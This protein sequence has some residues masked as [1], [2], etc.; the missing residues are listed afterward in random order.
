MSATLQNGIRL[1]LFL[2]VLMSI[3]V[4]VARVYASSSVHKASGLLET[5]LYLYALVIFCSLLPYKHTWIMALVCQGVA[6]FLDVAATGLGTLATFRCRNQTGCIKTLPV[7]V[8]TLGICAVILLL[9]VLQFWDIYRILRAPMFTSSAARRIR[10][11]FAWALPFG[12]LVNI[13][14]FMDSEWSMLKFS[15]TH[16]FVDPLVIFMANSN[17]YTFVFGLIVLA[18]VSDILAWNLHTNS[19]AKRATVILFGLSVG[20]LI[21]HM[22]SKDVREPESE[23]DEDE[24]DDEET[25][26]ATESQTLRHRKSGKS[27]IK[28]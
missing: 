24:K 21:I 5:N 8:L 13:V 6:T 11:L 1:R 26:E 9:D 4:R 10:I 20:A 2:I 22:L 17:E 25:F 27:K 14:L 16:L 19:L 23:Q 3:L 12:W 15:T 7:S 18:I 28:F